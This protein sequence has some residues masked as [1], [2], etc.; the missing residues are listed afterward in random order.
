MPVTCQIYI[1]PPRSRR[2]P[3]SINRLDLSAVFGKWSLWTAAPS[4]S[5]GTLVKEFWEVRG[6]VAAF[7][8]AVLPNGHVEMMFN[9]GP[10]HR[11]LDGPSAGEWTHSWFSG[12]HERAIQIESLDGTH[13]LCFLATRLVSNGRIVHYLSTP[14]K[15]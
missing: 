10:V 7:R 13:L 14:D 4:A 12:L 5:L 15:S 2:V 1:N 11:V 6:N 3:R 9:L 8:E